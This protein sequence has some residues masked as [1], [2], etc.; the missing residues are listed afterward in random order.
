MSAFS[1]SEVHGR[2]GEGAFALRAEPDNEFLWCDG[3]DV[4]RLL[5]MC[6]DVGEVG[7]IG[8]ADAVCAD[9]LPNDREDVTLV[10]E[11]A[12]EITCDWGYD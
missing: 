6:I 8:L 9:D 4:V 11:S 7:V 10:G 1:S 12:N 2:R 3:C 5:N